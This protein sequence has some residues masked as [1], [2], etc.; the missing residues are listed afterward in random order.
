MRCKNVRG[1]PGDDD[2]DRRHPPPASKDKGKTKEVAVKKRKRLSAEQERLLA[3]ADASALAARG[4]RSDSLRI[5]EPDPASAARALRTPVLGDPPGT[6]MIA[7]WRV[8]FEDLPP[9]PTQSDAPEAGGLDD[10]PEDA[11]DQPDD[12]VE[13]PESPP[14]RRST[15]SHSPV[16]PRAETQR[17]GGREP[18][19]PRGPPLVIHLD[20]RAATAHRVQELRFVEFTP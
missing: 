8:R 12:T 5:Q 7:G 9:M 16:T 6:V 19:R 13:Q 20:L 14:R 2:S 3:I 18:P 15:R 11:D 17:R 1:G 4:G 10:Q